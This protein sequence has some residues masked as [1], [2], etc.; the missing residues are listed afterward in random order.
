M[1]L[2]FSCFLGYQIEPLAIYT[3]YSSTSVFSNST[4][5]VESREET[6]LSHFCAMDL[7]YRLMQN[8]EQ[9]RQEFEEH[10]TRKWVA[11]EDQKRISF[12]RY[13]HHKA[14]EMLER[15]AEQTRILLLYEVRQDGTVAEEQ[16]VAHHD[17]EHEEQVEVD[18]EYP[19]LNDTQH[20]IGIMPQRYSC[21]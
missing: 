5:L 11:T 20:D 9:E 15:H 18:E 1:G 8:H 12:R 13:A 10:L 21:G 3:F 7:L 6:G 16:T 17:S 4:T 2:Q 19:P 14:T